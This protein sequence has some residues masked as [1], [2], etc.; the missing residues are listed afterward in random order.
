MSEDKEGQSGL[1]SLLRTMRFMNLSPDYIRQ[2][3]L[4]HGI[5]N[6]QT[7]VSE[8]RLK[9]KSV[10]LSLNCSND[11]IH[12]TNNDNTHYRTIKPGHATWRC[13]APKGGLHI[14]CRWRIL[15]AMPFGQTLFGSP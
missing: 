1:D 12:M 14:G 10:K 3:K 8:I 4:Y 13:H 15:D 2:G 5:L 7:I 11:N 9:L 6:Q